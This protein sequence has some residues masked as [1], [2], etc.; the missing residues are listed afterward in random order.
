MNTCI[1]ATATAETGEFKPWVDQHQLLQANLELR[2]SR[3]QI[4]YQEILAH[5]VVKVH[6]M[7][8]HPMEGYRLGTI[9]PARD[10]PNGERRFYKVTSCVSNGHGT[11]S[12]TLESLCSDPELPAIKLFRSTANAPYSLEAKPSI[13][14]DLNLL[15]APGYEGLGLSDDYERPFVHERTMP[16][17]LGY[18]TLAKK[19][20]DQPVTEKSTKAAYSDLKEANEELLMQFQ[21][22]HQRKTLKQ[23]LMAN[24]GALNDLLL[25]DES[26]SGAVRAFLDLEK[27]QQIRLYLFQT[28]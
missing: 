19:E 9:I 5:V 3:D 6:M 13:L 15:N 1:V 27:T 14:N 23:I 16:I 24:D 7:K 12:Y 11:V 10:G 22:A 2:A 8:E 18:Q 4:S 25:S 26:F 20:L 17:W 28:G 21:S